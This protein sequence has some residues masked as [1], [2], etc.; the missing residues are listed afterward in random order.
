MDPNIGINELERIVRLGS[1]YRGPHGDPLAHAYGMASMLRDIA[2]TDSQRESIATAVAKI[3]SWFKANQ[4][5]SNETAE[6]EHGALVA[7]K[8]LRRAYGI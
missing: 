5:S 3:V 1:N 2:V 8:S 7:I 6:L 4:I